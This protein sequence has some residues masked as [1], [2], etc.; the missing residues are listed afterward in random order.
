MAFSQQSRGKGL[1]GK[2]FGLIKEFCIEN[3][4]EAIRVDT[5][6]ENKVMQHVLGREGFAYCG[7]VTF[8]GG[9]KLAYEWD[10]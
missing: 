4:I 9:P 5:Q 1:S 6:D 3:G 7:L 10:R 8:D 2:A